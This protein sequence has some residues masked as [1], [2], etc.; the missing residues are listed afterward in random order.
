MELFARVRTQRRAS[1][2][3]RKN[4]DVGLRPRK[5]WFTTTEKPLTKEWRK[6]THLWPRQQ[7]V[8]MNAR[9]VLPGRHD[10][11]SK[12]M[13][14][15]RFLALVV[16]PEIFVKMNAVAPLSGMF[17][18]RL[19]RSGKSNNKISKNGSLYL[20]PTQ[21][22]ESRKWSFWNSCWKFFN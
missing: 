4:A 11:M 1:L 15:S 22:Y 5:Q 13:I 14:L 18:H 16:L 19:S 8:F 20:G 10:E 6:K 3:F 17:Y 7:N 2:V 9:S 12:R 21:R